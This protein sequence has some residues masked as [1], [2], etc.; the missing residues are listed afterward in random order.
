[1]PIYTTPDQFEDQTPSVGQ[2]LGT[3]LGT[4][5]GEGLEMLMKQ[6]MVN[7][8]DRN[9]ALI[10]REKEFGDIP[11]SVSKFAKDMQLEGYGADDHLKVLELAQNFYKQGMSKGEAAEKAWLQHEKDT[12]LETGLDYL[13][14]GFTGGVS[15][16]SA[17]TDDSLEPKRFTDLF[18]SKDGEPSPASKF[19]TDAFNPRETEAS[20]A[21]YKRAVE[22]TKTAKS[23]DE[24]TDGELLLLTSFDKKNL[25][26]KVQKE[27]EEKTP[28]LRQMVKQL[29]ASAAIPFIGGALEERL[30]ENIDP[31]LPKPPHAFAGARLAAELPALGPLL[32]GATIGTRAVKGAAIFGGDAAINEFIRTIGTD[33]PADLKSI[34]IQAG[35]GALFPFGEAAVKGMEKPFRNAIARRMQKG[36]TSGL[37]A[38]ES[39]LEDATKAGISLEGMQK[40]LEPERVKFV[41]FLEKDAKKTAEIVKPVPSKGIKKETLKLRAETAKEA[42]IRFAKEAE[43]LAKTPIEKY[44]EPKKILQKGYTERQAKLGPILKGLEKEIAT[45]EKGLLTSTGKELRSTQ[46][47]LSAL[48]ERK[49]S[50]NHEINYG[51]PSSTAAELTTQAEKSNSNL[52]DM[53]MNPTDDT[54]KAIQRNDKMMNTFLER[55]KNEVVKGKLPER[56]ATDTFLGIQDAH[57]KA[58]KELQK[59]IKDQMLIPYSGIRGSGIGQTVLDQLSTRIKGIEAA[60]AVQTQKR[61]TLGALKGPT[62]RFY[63]NW[64]DK[65]KGEQKL[66]SKDM[67]RIGDKISKAEKNITPIAKKRIEEAGATAVKKGEKEV[68][69]LAKEV[70]FTEKESIK[71]GKDLEELKSLP[72]FKTVDEY[73]KW[74]KKKTNNILKP[75]KN[76]IMLGAALGFVEEAVKEITGKKMPYEIKLGVYGSLGVPVTRRSRAKPILSITTGVSNWAFS[77]LRKDIHKNILQSKNGIE[78]RREYERLK[79]KGF[80]AAQLKEMR[81]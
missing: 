41:E 48:R 64:V 33:K 81:S 34:G 44:M 37:K 52:L 42:E 59:T 62:G 47:S 1:M 5:M 22:K 3:A 53:I 57:L 15:G 4:G 14:K 8:Q 26:E 58:Y 65:L 76:Q 20:K 67:I 19:I 73:L 30:R 2:R 36:A 56:I 61:K 23:L 13:K 45:A 35:L 29:H 54:L 38:T 25:P 66:L 72:E 12:K 50:I 55:A 11:A 68:V 31:D 74:V 78:R 43:T 40:G 69:K 60:Q 27:L 46:D 49:Y 7:L 21:L 75:A 28:E 18:K 10:S 51:K 79:K 39:L 16:A 71:I 24:F 17:L 77:A 63:R 6:K 32:K 80:T 9:K 70:G